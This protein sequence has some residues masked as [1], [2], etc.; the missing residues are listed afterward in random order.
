VVQRNLL[1]RRRQQEEHSRDGDVEK[2]P[3]VD[4]T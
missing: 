1:R 3:V 4:N 2:G